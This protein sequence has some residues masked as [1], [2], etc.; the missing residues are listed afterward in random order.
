MVKITQII[1]DIL[2]IPHR[3]HSTLQNLTTSDDHT[4]Y[5]DVANTR[6]V[7]HLVSGLDANKPA[8]PSVGDVYLASD[9]QNLYKCD[10]A[11]SWDKALVFP[12]GSGLKANIPLPAVKGD[13][14]LA[15]DTTEL[16]YALENNFWSIFTTTI[17][18]LTTVLL[19]TSGNWTCP[20]GLNYID[21]EI[22]G[23]GGGGG[24]SSSVPLA[25]S[26]GGSG[27]YQKIFSVSV[28][29]G[30]IYAFTIGAGGA[31]SV[32]PGNGSP[33]GNSVM[34]GYTS[35]GG[36]GGITTGAGGAGG[37]PG[38][39]VGVSGTATTAGNGGA[40]PYDGDYG[41][42]GTTGNGGAS[43]G[44]G[45]GGGGG[46]IVGTTYYNGGA[47]AQGIIRITYQTAP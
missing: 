35:T 15:T 17:P 40:S 46:A 22:Q 30:N 34:F 39:N 43:G 9:T 32:S 23:G 44:Y 11:G 8:S 14:Y 42:A 10:V 4:Q 36:A 25:G 12:G 31:G 27:G 33:G 41:A 45:G 24:A 38:G 18:N 7:N 13:S 37:T 21:V 19:T 28:T 26:G 20:A 3:L 47:G 5:Y 6:P 29:P 1:A 16:Y 2:Q